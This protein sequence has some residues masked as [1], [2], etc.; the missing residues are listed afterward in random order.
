MLYFEV[1]KQF[2][3]LTMENALG[4]IAFSFAVNLQTDTCSENLYNFLRMSFHK[5]LA[6]SIHPKYTPKVIACGL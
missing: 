6:A 2:R 4:E 1:E 5:G 3:A